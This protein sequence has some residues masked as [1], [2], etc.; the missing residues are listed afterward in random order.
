MQDAHEKADAKFKKPKYVSES[1]G[2]EDEQDQQGPFPDAK[3]DKAEAQHLKVTKKK[4]VSTL[5][6]GIETLIT[7]PHVPIFLLRMEFILS[8][9][10]G[11]L[12]QMGF[13]N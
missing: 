8:T 5:K 7:F 9:N 11:C 1:E 3:K 6:E 4:K 10:K 13:Y 12:A 2:S